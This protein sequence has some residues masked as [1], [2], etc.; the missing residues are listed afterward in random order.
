M[1]T[2]SGRNY[3]G[4]S[5]S[6]DRLNKIA[7]CIQSYRF[8]RK[9]MDENPKLMEILLSSESSEEFI[10]E[11]KNWVL[12]YFDTNPIAFSYYKRESRGIDVLKK[13]S[14]EDIAA[15]R[16]LDYI[17]NTGKFFAD[18]NITINKNLINNP[19][20]L[21]WLAAKYGK[22]GAKLDFFVDMRELFRQFSGKQKKYIP[23]SE[24]IFNWMDRHP[25]GF[26][27]HIIK[28]RKKNKKRIIENIIRNIDEGNSNHPKYSF[29]KQ[30][31]FEEKYKTVEQWWN[32]YK[33]H[34][35]FAVRTPDM[36]NRMLDHSISYEQM[37][38]LKNAQ[39]HEIPLFVNPYYLSLL[40]TSIVGFEAESD[41]TIRDYVF[42]NKSL[43]KE[44]GKIV[45]WEKEDKIVPGEPNAAGWILP[46]ENNL[47]RR[48]PEVA[49]MI[50]DTV[51]RACGGLCVS[52]Q[53][54]YDFQKGHL[55]FNLEK[56]KPKTSWSE[57]LKNLLTYF[58]NDT[59]LRDILIT[60]GDALMSS[61]RSIKEIL[62]EVLNM[63][64]RKK[65][66]NYKR[67][68][69]EKYAEIIRIRLGTRLLAYLPQRI[70]PKLVEILSEFKNRAE[71][72][73]IKQFIIQTHFESAMEV[74][75]EAKEA[76]NRIFSAGWIVTNQLVFTAAASRRGH[77]IKLRQV[78]N[79][80]G[81]LPYYTF[82]VKGYLENS[83]NFAPN[84]RSVQESFEEKSFGYV[85]PE[86]LPELIPENITSSNIGEMINNIKVKF[87][88][89]FIATDRNVLNLPG[90][91]KSITFRVIGITRYGKRI[92]EFEHDNT[93]NHSQVI[94]EMKKIYIVE[95]KSL[96]TYLHQLEEM[97]EDINDYSSIW[98]YS[99]GE[100]E[101]RTSLYKYPEYDFKTTKRITNFQMPER[102]YNK[103]KT[104]LNQLQIK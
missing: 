29:P 66:A 86:L 44:F 85:L 61:D 33:F 42:L 71:K 19:F 18:P 81:I 37:N 1:G 54:M 45:A 70:T 12:S 99:I 95:S 79:K 52:C 84:A 57:K 77:T 17:D 38:M 88:I 89:P 74:T 31:T 98:G 91:G 100:T 69:G 53:R 23:D 47:H 34:L 26:D 50:P 83:H 97:G 24:T 3:S 58:E 28:T 56:L 49:I 101:P 92:L 87:N 30:I 75:P 9:I 65:E 55:N 64:I 10:E 103:A 14:W 15:I 76:V 39:N 62:D 21:L 43:I 7:I 48:Y 5:K 16:I 82:T 11:I 51:G 72:V 41:R 60:G 36:L 59:Q 67:K 63:A 6:D 25:S 32:D 22:G 27:P 13:L 96:L 20:K 68:E 80:I 2:N 102:I 46:T 8:V 94:E 40:N 73:G 4:Y 90:V 93:R 104:M 35:T 78:L